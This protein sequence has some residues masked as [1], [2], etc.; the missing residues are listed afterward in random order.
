MEN[1]VEKP[2]FVWYYG[3]PFSRIWNKGAKDYYK[4]R[5]RY[6]DSFRT[7]SEKVQVKQLKMINGVSALII[8]LI[9]TLWTTLPTVMELPSWLQWTKLGMEDVSW[10]TNWGGAIWL[11]IIPSC[12][13]TVIH[14]APNW[15][16]HKKAKYVANA[17]IKIVPIIILIILYYLIH[18]QKIVWKYK[19]I[20]KEQ[21]LQK[22]SSSVKK[23]DKIKKGT[24]A[25]SETTLIDKENTTDE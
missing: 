24:T 8:L 25:Y 23:D 5:E 20:E 13:G 9:T 18:T 19:K 16:P 22:L 11:A 15:L 2:Q 10:K 12:A 4:D 21:L 7:E 17:I 3:L 14:K 1:K 6:D